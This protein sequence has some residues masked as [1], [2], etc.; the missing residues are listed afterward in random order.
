MVSQVWSPQ[1]TRGNWC[2][3]LVVGGVVTRPRRR[4]RRRDHHRG[5]YSGGPVG[6]RRETAVSRYTSDCHFR[7][8]P[9]SR[10]LCRRSNETLELGFAMFLFFFLNYRYWQVSRLQFS[11]IIASSLSK[12][13]PRLWTPKWCSSSPAYWL[14]WLWTPFSKWWNQV[15]LRRRET[16]SNWSCYFCRARTGRVAVRY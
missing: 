5:R 16:S 7:V 10:G 8:F 13:R 11:W 15:G 14:L 12:A 2:V 1:R 4:S 6:R 3:I 9:E